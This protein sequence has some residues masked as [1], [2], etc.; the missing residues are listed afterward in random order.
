MCCTWPQNRKAKAAWSLRIPWVASGRNA[1]AQQGHGS[2][3]L[4]GWLAISNIGF[5]PFE[6][7]KVIIYCKSDFLFFPIIRCFFKICIPMSVTRSSSCSAF[8]LDSGCVE[9]LLEHVLLWFHLLCGMDM[10]C[11]DR[12]GSSLGHR[13]H[14]CRV[15]WSL[16]LY[17]GYVDPVP[18]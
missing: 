4:L 11:R 8:W 3:T 17:R 5:N 14:S 13:G 16:A 2:H 6:V 12:T 15:P 18:V 9:P 1:L 10:S 7:L